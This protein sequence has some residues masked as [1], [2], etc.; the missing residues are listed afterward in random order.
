MSKT[1][2]LSM[3]QTRAAVTSS[4]IDKENRTVEVVFGTDVPVRM[5]NWDIGRYME[6][7]SFDPAHVRMDRI[8]AGAPLLKMHR[9]D[10]Q[11][12]VVESARVE[13]GK[14]VAVIRFSKNKDAE[15]VWNDVVD[16]IVRN[17][18]VGYNVYEYLDMSATDS[19]TTTL[20]AIDWEPS[21]ISIVSVPA[22]FEAGVRSEKSENDHEVKISQ[23]N[24][25]RKM[26][27]EET[28]EAKQAR[29][30]AEAKKKSD[31]EAKRKAEDEAAEA[32]TRG[33]GT[34]ESDVEKIRQQAIAGEKSRVSEITQMTRMAKLPADF[35]QKMIDDNVSIEKARKMIFDEF[36]KADPNKGSSNVSVTGADEVD[37]RRE[38]MTNAQLL[39]VF[40]DAERSKLLTPDQV[41]AAREY[42]SDKLFDMV[43]AS[44]DHLGIKHRGMDPMDMVRV[45]ITS[46]GSD[47]PILLSGLNRQ[48]LLRSYS[49]IPDTWR[50]FSKVGSVSDFRDW[51]RL[52]MGS[53]GNLD[54]VG[55]NG[56]FKTKKINDAQYEKVSLSTK[57]NLINISRQMIINDDLGGIAEYASQLGRAAARSIESDV[58]GQF[59]L[60][61]GNGPTMVDGNPLFHASHGNI[62][63]T[64]AAPTTASFDA[65][66]VQM[67]GIKDQDGNDFLDIQPS[68]WLGPSSLKGAADL[69]NK[70]Q[71]EVA[72]AR[73]NTTPNISAGLFDQIIDTP[74]LS[75]TAWYAFADPNMEPVFE[76]VFL[77]GQETP[78]LESQMGYEVD[79]M[80]WKIRHDWG[81]APIG[82]RGVVKNAGA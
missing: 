48:I 75:G 38:A 51:R 24:K 70:S 13:N 65:I 61:S 62:A 21:E 26:E 45:A 63:G 12:G 57:G 37:K 82:F 46:S 4:S 32:R 8:N 56:E 5:Y 29:L 14:G 35:A 44:L 7:L 66:R 6:I 77:N 74:R 18:S 23:L 10:E 55:E 43:R 31:A 78:S 16:G 11:I 34:S 42:R 67:K 28:P 53:I 76:V 1:K 25:S 81:V 79:G 2:K 39:R 59:S 49:A 72:T 36:E 20:K 47:L 15:E 80:S 71:Y 3:L 40:P 9:K 17:I 60:N 58:Y 69:V 30:D 52:R 68:I 41:S 73:N 27:D 64:A 22:D 54:T 50:R 33:A 19:D